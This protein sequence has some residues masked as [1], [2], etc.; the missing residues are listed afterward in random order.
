MRKQRLLGMGLPQPIN[1]TEFGKRKTVRNSER[2]VSHSVRNCHYYCLA[3]D[4]RSLTQ[5]ASRVLSFVVSRV[6]MPKLGIQT[7]LLTNQLSATLALLHHLTQN[8]SSRMVLL[9]DCSLNKLECSTKATSSHRAITA[10]APSVPYRL[11]H[12]RR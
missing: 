4:M 5:F 2:L 8:F 11:R 6:R 9:E 7:Y 12:R 3:N 1:Q 10:R